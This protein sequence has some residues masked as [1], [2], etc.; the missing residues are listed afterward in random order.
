MQQ[1]RQN[2]F[3][4]ALLPHLLC[5]MRHISELMYAFLCSRLR[6]GT[7]IH[8]LVRK[9]TITFHCRIEFWLHPNL[10]PRGQRTRHVWSTRTFRDPHM[11]RSQVHFD[12]RRTL[13]MWLRLS[14]QVIWCSPWKMTT[15]SAVI[16]SLASSRL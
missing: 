16:H 11:S 1:Y 5:A 15:I 13:P 4:W 10:M 8:S 9:T 14:E 6:I 2:P 3:H 12:N 7:P